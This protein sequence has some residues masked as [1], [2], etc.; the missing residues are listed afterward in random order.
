MNNRNID[1]HCHFFNAAF[2]FNEL[3]EAGWRLLHG[4]Y[5]YKSNELLKAKAL[6]VTTRKVVGYVK[7]IASLLV[8]AARS[9]QANYDY[10][11][12][13]YAK[14]QWHPSQ[15]IITVP[16][17]MDIFFAF[18]NG[19]RQQRKT[20]LEALPAAER[21]TAIAPASVSEREIPTFDEFAKKMKN[22]VIEEYKRQAARKSVADT[23]TPKSALP[24][25]RELDRVIATFKAEAMP[26]L[27]TKGLPS[28]G[29][30]QMTRGYK[31]HLKEL[32]AL[33][34]KNPDTVFPFLAVD[35]RRIGIEKLVRDQVV[36]GSF[37]GVKLYCPL[38]YLPSHPYLYPIYKLCIK[39]HIP[40][41]AHTSPGG[42][43]S[44]CSNIRT[45]SRKKDGTVVPVVFD[46]KTFEATHPVKKGEK[47]QSLFFANP[48]NWTEV[49]ESDG[50][51]T[52][53]INF[54][55][56]GGQED[57]KKYA[58][59]SA[60]PTNWTAR[61]IGLMNR[62]KHV[63]ADISFC[64]DDDMLQA[65]DAIVSRHPIVEERL[66]FGTDF[67]ML[68]IDKIGL[69]NYFN[70]YTGIKP[71]MMTANPQAFLRYIQ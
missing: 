67:V 63:Y 49:I 44:Q 1:V 42:F 71:P 50:L 29:N 66:M 34:K 32:K 48:E 19:S 69:R 4:D 56:F 40:V 70:Q 43:P 25:V 51:D 35:P 18:D 27:A 22:M 23:Y 62:F 59:G 38:G 47:A 6:A 15:P 20:R 60:D 13:C 53:H 52:L 33:R 7:Y 12:D 9:P 36:R 5:P 28:G 17:M 57:I 31:K 58:T 41:T 16:L 30:V 61:I 10:E 14:S 45:L 64:P 26:A 65:I 37:H 21:K 39:H 68:M 54:A 2:A 8:T 11:Q 55:H 3:L 46:K 24:V